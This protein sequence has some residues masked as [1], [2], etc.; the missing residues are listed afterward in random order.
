[1]D[2]T[3][4]ANRTVVLKFIVTAT[5]T[6]SNLSFAK[7]WVDGIAIGPPS[8][9]A[10]TT[11][12]TVNLTAPATGATVSGPVDVAATASDSGGVS[13]VE[14]YLDGV[15]VDTDTTAPYGFTWDTTA[16][17]NG[18][19]ALMAK[20]YDGANNI[21]TDNDTAVTVSNTGGGRTTVAFNSIAADDG[22]VKANA[23]GSAPAL[24]TLSTPA[25][26]RGTDSKLNRALFSFDTSTIPDTARIVR[27]WLK[28]TWSS[29]SGDPWADPVGNT[30]QVDVKNG[31]FGAAA[32][33]T[34]DFTAAATAT[35]VAHI[36]K[37]ASGTQNS[38][39]FTAAG[40]G[41]LNTEGKTQVKLRFALDSTGTRY[42]FLT[43]GAGAVLTV[44]YE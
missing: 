7:A 16:T 10:D 12:P 6:G 9:N 24:G 30:L 23:D 41:A 14:F 20:A 18:G 38:T 26:G 43:E 4:F 11:P 27:A 17:A 34:T 8:A 31:T 19:H 22:Y 1:V 32:I 42:L 39:D 36:I 21:G 44:E 2:L 37:F 33:E 25:L 28:V 29:G 5:D 3:A 35:N 15:L 13:K 40:L